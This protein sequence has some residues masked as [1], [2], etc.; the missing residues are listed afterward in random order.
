MVLRRFG[1]AA[2]SRRQAQAALDLE[3]D[4]AAALVFIHELD[5]L[6]ADDPVLR[7]RLLRIRAKA[8]R[9]D[10]APGSYLFTCTACQAAADQSTWASRRTKR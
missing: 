2:E 1:R 8:E 4:Y 10:A 9:L 6:P 5:G 3:P 7:Q